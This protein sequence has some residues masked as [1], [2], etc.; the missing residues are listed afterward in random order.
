MYTDMYICMY[1]Q[2]I[3]T[4][5]DKLLHPLL[6]RARRAVGGLE[7]S[8]GFSFDASGGFVGSAGFWLGCGLPR[9]S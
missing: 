4:E 3:K 1:I 6:P 8:A 5:A 7:G 2:M 9:G